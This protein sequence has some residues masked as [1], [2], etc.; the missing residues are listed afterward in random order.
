VPVFLL[1]AAAALRWLWLAL[2]ARRLRAA[3]LALL[4]LAAASALV[5]LPIVREDLSMAYY[6]LGNRY[7]D[8]QR[9]DLAIEQYA[10]SLRRNSR[11]I[12]AWNNL[13][14]VYERSGS[15]ASEAIETWQTVLKLARQQELERYVER[16]S[17]HLQ[18]LGAGPEPA[19]PPAAGGIQNPEVPR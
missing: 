11:Y 17:R 6:N 8:L 9:W 15:H 13:A 5:H 19:Q 2:R 4:G 1:F 7:K 10:Q 16:A 18:T 3:G 14:L 12:S